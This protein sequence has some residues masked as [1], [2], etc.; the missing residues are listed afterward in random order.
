MVRI[1]KIDA[2]IWNTFPKCLCGTSPPQTRRLLMQIGRLH[3]RIVRLLPRIIRFLPKMWKASSVEH[4][5]RTHIS[6]QESHWTLFTYLPRSHLG[7]LRSRLGLPC[8]C[9]SR[10]FGPVRERFPNR[11]INFKDAYHRY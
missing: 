3:P 4:W 9:L 2:V 5:V 10:N 7:L 11:G 8:L 6:F 1:F